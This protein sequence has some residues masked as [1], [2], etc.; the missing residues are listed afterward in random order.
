[1][2]ALAEPRARI[3][4]LRGFA[5]AAAGSRC[6][7]CGAAMA[8]DHPHLLEPARRQ[9]LCACP[10][11]AD[12]VP[13]GDSGGYCRIPRQGQALPDFRMTDGQWDALL[14]PVGLAFF[15]F[16]SADGRTVALYPGPAGATESLLSL[17][18][19]D[20]LMADNPVLGTFEPDVEAL[21]VNRAGGVGAYY[22]APID[23]C[24]GL[25]G[26]LRTHWHGLSGG[27][28]AWDGIHA[29]FVRLDQG[30]RPQVLG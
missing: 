21:L 15:F 9:V 29:F 3:A 16:S 27:S 11:C 1:M 12:N 30:L 7:V 18:A 8:S 22:R 13:G 25:V 4:T 19:W 20:A 5:R 10:V 24:Y 26:L 23:W 14:I 2:S 17:D 28:D 6:E